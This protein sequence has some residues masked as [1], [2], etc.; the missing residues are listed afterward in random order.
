MRMIFRRNGEGD[1]FSKKTEKIL[2]SIKVTFYAPNLGVLTDF[3]TKDR[4]DS[5]EGIM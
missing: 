3:P 1:L 5:T 4:R 2:N